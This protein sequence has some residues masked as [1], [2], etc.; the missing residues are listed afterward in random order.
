MEEQKKKRAKGALVATFS[1]GFLVVVVAL[2]AVVLSLR[3]SQNVIL[4][5]VKKDLDQAKSTVSTPELTRKEGLAVA[6][7]NKLDSVV[8]ILNQETFGSYAFALV[9]KLSPPGV[10]LSSI[11]I[12]N[13]GKIKLTVESTNISDLETLMNNFVNPETNDKKVIAASVESFGK[14]RTEGYR[15]DLTLTLT[16]AMDEKA[17]PPP[18]PTK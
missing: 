12:N 10:K 9:D 11:T 14:G 18:A 6:L 8:T 15:L 4:G 3:L 5:Q 16:G 7:K 1:I 17:P 13:K 2:A